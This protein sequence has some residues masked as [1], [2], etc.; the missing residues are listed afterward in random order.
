MKCVH[1]IS[2]RGSSCWQCDAERE[3]GS[4]QPS[5]QREILRRIAERGLALAQCG[6]A[7]PYANDGA[8][9]EHLDLWQHMIDEL[10]RLKEQK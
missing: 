1:G 7:V 10:Q 5:E 4:K 2:L 6:A 3:S 8:H 9:K